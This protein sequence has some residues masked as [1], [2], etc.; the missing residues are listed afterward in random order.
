MCLRLFKATFAA[1]FQ[2]LCLLLICSQRQ[3][4]VKAFNRHFMGSNEAAID[5][6]LPTG[7]LPLASAIGK[8]KAVK[9]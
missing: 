5:H 1:A 6:F 3:R 2:A 8:A 9:V 4:E 7:M